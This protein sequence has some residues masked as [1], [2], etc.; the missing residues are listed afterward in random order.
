MSNV[1]GTVN[2]LDVAKENKIRITGKII[3]LDKSNYTLK[4]KAKDG[5]KIIDFEK[6]TQTTLYLKGKGS[7]KGGFSKFSPGD[8]VY[9]MSIPD[10][11]EENRFHALRIINIPMSVIQSTTAVSPPLTPKP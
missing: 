6:Y 11:K 3:D 7:Q 4:V 8:T 2:L 1:V 9:I 10:Q 5:E